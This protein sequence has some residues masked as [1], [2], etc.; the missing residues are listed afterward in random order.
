MEVGVEYSS[1][2]GPLRKEMM[3]HFGGLRRF[4]VPLQSWDNYYVDSHYLDIWLPHGL[5]PEMLNER[6]PIFIEHNKTGK[7]V[8]P[9]HE[10][11]I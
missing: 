9:G 10:N 4:R 7:Q 11:G 1:K 3:V 8:K 2:N 6:F 5:A